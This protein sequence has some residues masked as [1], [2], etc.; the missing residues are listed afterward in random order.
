M[1]NLHFEGFLT[2]YWMLNVFVV[3]VVKR[4]EWKTQNITH[5]FLITCIIT[6]QTEVFFSSKPTR[7]TELF[8]RFL[9]CIRSAEDNLR[10][11]YELH[12]FFFCTHIYVRFPAESHE[13]HTSRIR[14]RVSSFLLLPSVTCIKSDISVCA[15]NTG[16]SRHSDTRPS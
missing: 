6:F 9:L 13:F 14:C 15:R 1:F 4:K 10:T 7:K 11:G 5:S 8:L 16:T 3:Y 12:L 2:V